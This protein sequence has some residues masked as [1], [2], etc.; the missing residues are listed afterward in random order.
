[1]AKK[2]YEHEAVQFIRQYVHWR[3]KREG[4]L[5][6]PGR[7]P[8]LSCEAFGEFWTLLNV[9]LLTTPEFGDAWLELRSDDIRADSAIVG[10]LLGQIVR[11]LAAMPRDGS[12]RVVN[13][14]LIQ[15]KTLLAAYPGDS[16]EV[17]PI[18]QG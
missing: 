3:R 1:M 4:I 12:S 6:V 14:L 5:P 7:K 15:S 10:G 13:T 9:Q 11:E 16:I 17:F 2:W 8:E 18:Q